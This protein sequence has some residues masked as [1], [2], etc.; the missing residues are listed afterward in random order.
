MA[1][2][3]LLFRGTDRRNLNQSPEQMQALMQKWMGWMGEIT[4]QGKMVAAQPL[5]SSGKVIKGTKKVIT[6]GPFAEGK[7]VIGGYLLCKAD[8]IDEAI[9]MSKGCPILEFDEGTVEVRPIGQM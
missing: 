5:E 4:K 9:E 3:L 6:D 2:F 8:T 1:E 7:E